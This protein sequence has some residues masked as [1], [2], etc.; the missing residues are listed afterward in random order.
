MTAAPIRL[1]AWELPYAMSVALKRP[2]RK[3]ISLVL[4][5]PPERQ[6]GREREERQR[7]KERKNMD[8]SWLT[9]PFQPMIRQ[10]ILWR[11][12]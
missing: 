5:I 8:M 7:E 11:V 1:V 12:R 9:C 10:I 6:K 2:P 3:K 4:V